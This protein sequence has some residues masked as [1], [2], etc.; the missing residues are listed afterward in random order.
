MSIADE[1]L[2]LQTTE[3]KLATD[4]ID[5]EA[6]ITTKGGT[7][8][9]NSGF[10]TFAADIATIPS[11]DDTEFKNLIQRTGTSITIPNGT[12]KIGGHVF[13]EYT[14]IRN[15]IIPHSVTAIGAS[16]FSGCTNLADIVLP[17]I[18]TLGAKFMEN[19]ASIDRIVIPS[20]T[21]IE[22]S[23]FS[24]CVNLEIAIL[25]LGTNYDYYWGI[26][27]SAFSNCKKLQKIVIASDRAL[28]Q[29][30]SLNTFSNTPFAGYNSLVGT[31]YVPHIQVTTG[32][33]TKWLKE[34]YQEATNWSSLYQNGTCVF[35][36][37]A[38]QT[39]AG[40][41]T[42]TAFTMTNPPS[43]IF[44]IRINGDYIREYE[45][46]YENGVITF[47]EAPANNASIV[48]FYDGGTV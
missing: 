46:T 17:N 24:G 30:G 40:D 14:N 16:A 25:L 4:K 28:L 19:C 35:V 1:I 15:I 44:Y 42:T 29:L 22:G 23:S 7:L 33:V 41:G 20:I 5:I 45:Y 21:S 3:G 12:T 18:V 13:Q 11:Q 39:F 38:E 31:A 32:G 37:M 27:N 47:N 9:Q 43:E 34:W 26:R 10:D 6:V 8:S 48:V 2:E 36:E